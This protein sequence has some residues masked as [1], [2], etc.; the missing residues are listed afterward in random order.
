[1]Q[2]HSGTWQT[3]NE[4]D[5]DDVTI[6]HRLDDAA[7]TYKTRVRAISKENGSLIDMR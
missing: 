7:R 1:M 4:C 2:Q 6:K 3:I 5:A